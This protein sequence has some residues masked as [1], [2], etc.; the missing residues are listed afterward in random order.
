MP[1]VALPGERSGSGLRIPA[2]GEGHA[3]AHKVLPAPLALE[4]I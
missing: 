1:S 3:L 2:G 4:S